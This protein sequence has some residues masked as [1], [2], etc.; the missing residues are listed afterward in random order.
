MANICHIS[1]IE[2]VGVLN[3]TGLGKLYLM[4]INNMQGKRM[5]SQNENLPKLLSDV[6][7]NCVSAVK[8]GNPFDACPWIMIEE[9]LGT[10]KTEELLSF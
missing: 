9:M 6:I 7:V 10:K 4:S 5:E 2:G 1:I 8:N 3:D